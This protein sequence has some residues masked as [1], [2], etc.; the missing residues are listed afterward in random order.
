MKKANNQ[1]GFTLLELII[2]VGII[3]A[4]ALIA[5]P[6]IS[7]WN[8][9]RAIQADLAAI[10]ARIDFA[11]N[12]S[13]SEGRQIRLVIAFGPNGPSMQVR[14]RSSAANTPTNMNSDC[15][16]TAGQN[17]ASGYTE[18]YN[19]DVA[20]VQTRHGANGEISGRSYVAAPQDSNRYQMNN[21]A[22]CFN[23]DGTSSMGGFQLQSENGEQRYRIDVF[24]TGFYSV[25]RYVDNGQ[26]NPN[27]WVEW[28]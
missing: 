10:Q 18:E 15:L 6:N 20:S 8:R 25:E 23:S 2:V 1:K 4:I 3:G 19:F 26:C 27:C 14:S 16:A 17:L 7:S 5:T 13:V 24:Q 12:A 9:S 28:N 22:I 21:S 11:K